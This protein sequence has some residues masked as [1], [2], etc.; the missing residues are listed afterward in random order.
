MLSSSPPLFGLTNGSLI[1]EGSN[2][3][4]KGTF[5]LNSQLMFDGNSTNPCVSVYISLL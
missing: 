2:G 4:L 5:D 1:K 3:R